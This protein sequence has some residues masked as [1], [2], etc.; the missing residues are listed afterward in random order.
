MTPSHSSYN[1][2]VIA[3]YDLAEVSYRDIWDLDRSMALHYGYWDDSIKTFPQSL[4]KTNQVLATWLTP[5]SGDHILDAGCGVGGSSIFLA[6]TF[7]C[8]VT[9]ISLSEKQVA[10]AQKNAIRFGIDKQCRFSIADYTKTGFPDASFDAVWA[11][12][13]VCHALSKKDFLAEAFRVLKPGGKLIMADGFK[14]KDLQ[15]NEH[16]FLQQWL[17]GWSIHDLESIEN[18]E[19]FASAIGY[20]QIQKRDL[21]I[22]IRPTSLRMY[23]FG[24]L[25]RFYGKWRALLG[26]KYGNS[27][28]INNTIGAIVQYQ[29]L[30]R[31]LWHYSIF[32]AEKGTEGNTLK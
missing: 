24:L 6:Q 29:A 3:Y 26:K 30:K 18:M 32:F 27:Y 7:D 19:V 9:G 17:Q 8:I 15:E 23:R 4:L 22:H 16:Q 10:S 14:K 2:S 5:K 21:S 11:L 20:K 31:K 1:E 13:S 28:T 12:E 25:A